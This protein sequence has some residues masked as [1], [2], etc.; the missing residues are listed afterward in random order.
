MTNNEIRE[1]M[2]AARE[3]YI[4]LTKSELL[5]PGS[6]FSIP[7]AEHEL[8][9][10]SPTSRY[11]VGILYP[12]GNEISQDNDETIPK[13]ENGEGIAY[14]FEDSFTQN[15]E[16]N[17]TITKAIRN[18]EY[19]ETAQ[20]NLDEEISLS[21][22]YMPSSMGITFI[23]RGK[24]DLVHGSADFATYRKAKVS[25]CIIPYVPDNSESYSIPPELEHKMVY[26]KEL[27]IIKLISSINAKEVRD[28]FERD[29]IPEN[30]SFVLKR[31]AYRFVDFCRNGYVRVPHMVEFTLDFS[32]SD[33]IDNNRELDGT[34]A[35]I[36]ALRT[37][38]SDNLWSITVMLVNDLRETPAKPNNCIFQ[39]F[40]N[41]SSEKNEFVFVETELN[42]DPE[43]MDDEEHSLELQYRHKKVYGTGLGVSV[44]WNINDE[45][46]GSIWSEFFPIA[47]VAPMDFNLPVNDKISSEK[48]SM[49]YL[50]DLDPTDKSHK[51]FDLK[52]MVDLYKN[53]LKILKILLKHLIY[54]I[55]RQQLKILQNANA[56]VI[57]CIQEL[58]HCEIMILHIML[59]CWQTEQCLCKE[60]T[61][62]CK[63]KQPT[64]TVILMICK[65]LQF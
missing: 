12:Q 1:Q 64:K 25:D 48:L 19:D 44:D 10:S 51:L 59:L 28:I 8:I 14:E 15:D 24:T 52:S 46:K 18:C 3:E 30:E 35:K 36:T 39:P 63:Q 22:Q 60:Y 20:E 27:K 58:K 55:N 38:I 6:E 32:Q 17:E 47:E 43:T 57:E 13:E 21:S 16:P 62:K 2:I 4:Q 40:I 26:D 34:T 42:D 53:G 29:T 50:S 54:D 49:K 5:G 7:D 37:R 61:L 65:L 56:L 45:G 23:V 9:S 33:Y 31:I 11:S 41:V